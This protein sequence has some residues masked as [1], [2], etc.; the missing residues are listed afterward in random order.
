M[1][2]MERI[3]Q[4]LGHD[5]L[6]L[7]VRYAYLCFFVLLALAYA[8]G[9]FFLPEGAMKALPLPSLTI[10]EGE[11]SFSSLVAR[12]VAYNLFGLL[13][14]VGMNH[15]RVRRFT[16][17]YLPVY[18]NTFL[19]GLFAGTNSFSGGI[20]TYTVEGWMMFLRIGFLEFSAYILVCAATVG[21][22][23]FHADRWRG[24]QFKRIRRFREDTLSTQEIGVLFGALGILIV[25]AF[26]EWKY[27]GW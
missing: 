15:F 4:G 9:L 16:F 23:M 26:N 24:E 20:S 7:R 1:E 17:G 2:S 13:L 10:F 19:M 21:L 27:V 6:S 18:A 14:I 8:L 5:K 22:A 11:Q 3:L 12:T 25:A